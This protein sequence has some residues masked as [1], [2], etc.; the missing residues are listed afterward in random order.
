MRSP[1]DSQMR[2]RPDREV[3]HHEPLGE[4]PRGSAA[5][6]GSEG[7]ADARAAPLDW[8]AHALFKG[9]SD[10]QRAQ[11]RARLR[12]VRY[13]KDELVVEEGD[14]SDDV[15][16]IA[17]GSVE[18]SKRVPGSDKDQRLAE[19]HAGECFGELGLLDRKPRSASIRALEPTR[20][21]ALSVSDVRGLS[22]GT[23]SLYS[24]LIRNLASAMAQRLRATNELAA[25]SMERELEQMRS[26][27][28]MGTFLAYVVLLMSLYGFVL[29]AAANMAHTVSATTIVTVPII[30]GLASSLFI[31]MLR[32]HYPM[33][34]YGLTLEKWKAHCLQA[35]LW[36]LPVLAVITLAKFVLIHTVPRLSHA[37]LF[38]IYAAVKPGAA[39]KSYLVTLMGAVYLALV[40]LQEFV[41][42][43]ALQSSLQAFLVGHNST[44]WAILISNAMFSASHLHLSTTFALL[45][46]PAGVFWG[47]LFSRQGSLV[48]PTLSHMLVG[49]WTLFVLGFEALM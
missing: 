36:T 15:F 31:M 14:S 26:R 10:D 2:P 35:L 41:A 19:L 29:R 33:R 34:M 32:L 7:P 22:A 48:G 4:S 9:L 21:W 8:R 25:A 24:V 38:D 37:P 28:A 20:L 13:G 44:F 5:A 42:R 16:I 45:V 12:Q 30:L 49:W 40:P 6:A 39:D 1:I 46:F 43:G 17:L 18:V 3:V 47:I 23:E 27:V 11:L